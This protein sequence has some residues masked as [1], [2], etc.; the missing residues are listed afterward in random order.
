MF[1]YSCDWCGR[2]CPLNAISTV[3]VKNVYAEKAY[4]L[5]ICRDCGGTH[6]PG[7]MQPMLSW[8]DHD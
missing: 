7:K 8:T 1:K 6:M 4:V 2:D 3:K 5:H